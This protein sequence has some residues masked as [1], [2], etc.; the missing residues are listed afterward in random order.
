MSVCSK[1]IKGVF[2]GA[3]SCIRWR[4]DAAQDYESERAPRD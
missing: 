3:D 1:L 2:D 4:L